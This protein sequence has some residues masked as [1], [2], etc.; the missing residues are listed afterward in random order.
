MNV[1]FASNKYGTNVYVNNKKIHLYVEN[2]KVI[3][4][5]H[6]KKENNWYIIIEIPDDIAEFIRTVESASVEHV[7]PH[8]CVRSLRK[9]IIDVRIPFRYRK[10]ECS[11]HD[12][13]NSRIVSEDIKENDNICLNLELQT[14][15]CIESIYGLLWRTDMIKK[16]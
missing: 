5:I 8:S 15:W 6:S 1:S 14:L 7:K 13:D 4:S 9:N 10:F 16:M 11:F 2:C 12:S 3:Q